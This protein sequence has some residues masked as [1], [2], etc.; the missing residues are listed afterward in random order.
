[1]QDVK[2]K[3]DYL[4]LNSKINFNFFSISP[5]KTSLNFNKSKKN[6]KNYNK[7]I[8]VGN[9]LLP[10]KKI[11][12]PSKNINSNYIWDFYAEGGTGNLVKR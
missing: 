12:F 3:N 11:D 8:I 10:P 7:K 2:F 9:G 6:K 1:M 5:N 4:I